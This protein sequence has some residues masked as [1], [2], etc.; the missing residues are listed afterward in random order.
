MLPLEHSAILLTCIKRKLVLKTNVGILLGWPLKTGF[1]VF[2]SLLLIRVVFWDTHIDLQGLK[3]Q[4]FMTC[5]KLTKIVYYISD[6]Q[7]C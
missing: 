4:F 3:V 5:L 6:T 2:D 1:T 7:T